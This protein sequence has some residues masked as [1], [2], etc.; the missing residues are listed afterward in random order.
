MYTITEGNPE[1]QRTLLIMYRPRTSRVTKWVLNSKPSL[2]VRVGSLI[3]ADVWW[4][5]T[6]GNTIERDIAVRSWV[7]VAL[8]A[9]RNAVMGAGVGGAINPL[10]IISAGDSR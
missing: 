7:L 5:R 2:L 8:V 1:I 4:E 6:S 10:S 3:I 9:R